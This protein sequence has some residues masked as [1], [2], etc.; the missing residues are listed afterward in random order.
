MTPVVMGEW[1]LTLL[2]HVAMSERDAE[3]LLEAFEEKIEA[4]VSTH[5]GRARATSAKL[6][7][8]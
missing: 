1:R 4:A 5:N 2:G 3:N 8:T 7:R 6:E